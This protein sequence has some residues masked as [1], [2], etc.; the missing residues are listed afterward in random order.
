MK[1]VID[2][3]G[4]LGAIGRH[5]DAFAGIDALVQKQAAA[6]LTAQLKHKSLNVDAFRAI[7]SAIGSEPFEL[8]LDT[9]DDKLLKAIAKK[10]DTHAPIAKSNDDDAM[11]AHLLDLANRRIEPTAKPLKTPKPDKKSAKASPTEPSDASLP[12]AIATKPPGRR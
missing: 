9:A 6:L 1:V 7:V 2:S 5:R 10:L 12:H 4:L 3:Y 8:F 11:R